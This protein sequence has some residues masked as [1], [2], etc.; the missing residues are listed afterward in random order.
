M[1]R[2]DLCRAH[3]PGHVQVVAAGMRD[4]R[5]PAGGRV[6]PGPGAGIGQAGVLLHRQ[7]V[8]VRA[9][10]DG[11]S[12]A[13]AQEPDDARSAHAL[14][15]LEP[16]ILQP[17]RRDAGRAPLLHGEFGMGME[18]LVDPPQ[19]RELRVGRSGQTH[20]LGRGRRRA[21]EGRQ[22]EEHG[23]GRCAANIP[24]DHRGPPSA[25]P[26]DAP[27]DDARLRRGRASAARKE[28]PLN[29]REGGSEDDIAA[30]SS[31][32]GGRPPAGAG[33]RG[34]RS[35]ARVPAA[36]RARRA[37]RRRPHRLPPPRHRSP[38]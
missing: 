9:Q 1:G 24:Y 36:R 11:G 27:F 33:R 20:R 12:V 21:H 30:A 15:N 16:E 17:A 37:T 2:Q 8:H 34:S 19:R 4:R 18:I 32:A 29:Y 6:G 13:V 5:C 10:Q 25:E 14:G 3:Q 35:R 23:S 38:G 7:R 26:R 22:H 31:P 28:R